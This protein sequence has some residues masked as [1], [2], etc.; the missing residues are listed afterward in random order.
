M[1]QESIDS[2]E[3]EISPDSFSLKSRRNRIKGYRKIDPWCFVH[4]NHTVEFT[5]PIEIENDKSMHNH[6][7]MSTL[8]YQF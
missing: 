2:M 7:N 5:K 6:N 3:L 1:S 8:F 4:V